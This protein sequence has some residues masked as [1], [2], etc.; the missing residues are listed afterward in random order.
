MKKP[1]VI[2]LSEATGTNT[3]PLHFKAGGR[4][5][6]FEVPERSDEERARMAQQLQG[7]RSDEES[8]DL[9][10]DWLLACSRDGLS[11]AE[12]RELIRPEPVLAQ[13]LTVLLTGRLPD[14]KKMDLLM[15]KLADRL[16]DEVIEAI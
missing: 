2:D 14:K 16:M 9:A 6:R 3:V 11:R 4:V 13:A 15:A 10:T 1:I 8:L 7:C 12:V 5:L